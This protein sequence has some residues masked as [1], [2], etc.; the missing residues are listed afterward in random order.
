MVR[1]KRGSTAL[2]TASTR[3]ARISAASAAESV[4]S[5][6]AASNRSGSPSE[7]T[8]AV[9]RAMSR[10]AMT[11]RSKKSRRCAIRANA[12]PTPPAPIT[13]MFIDLTEALVD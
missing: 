8:D 13:R 9:A 1:T 11:I 5:T 10:S 12:V 6:Y 3:S 2:R 4:A 7:S